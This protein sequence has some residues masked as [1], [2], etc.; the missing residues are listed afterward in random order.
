AQRIRLASQ[1]GSGLVGA[2]YV[3]DEPTIGLHQR[4]NERLIKTLLNLRDLG[5]TIIVVEHD[6]DTIYSSDYLVDIGPGAGVHG[7][8]IVVADETEKLLTA[9]KN[10][11]NSL[12][13]D[14]LRGDKSIPI[15]DERRNSEKGKIKIRGGNLF[16]IKNLNVDIPLGK[17]VAVSGVSGSGKSTFVYEILYKNLQGRFDRR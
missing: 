9:K 7:G 8:N 6:E 17:L 1:L 11:F 5:N 3:L 16:N 4:D 13:V 15:P 12:T 14:Y 2:L 10:N